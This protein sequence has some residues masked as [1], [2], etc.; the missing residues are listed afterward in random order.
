MAFFKY[1]LNGDIEK[2]YRQIFDTPFQRILFRNS[3]RENVNDFKLN[4]VTF[5]VNCA[6]YLAI[7]TSLKL[8]NHCERENPY[9]SNIV[10]NYM[11]MDE[12]LFGSHSIDDAIKTLR[13]K[14][15]R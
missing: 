1:V 11:Y 3:P 4:T 8:A 9:I 10:R 13:P 5:G 15:E 2:I 12:L 14:S 7:R 6:L